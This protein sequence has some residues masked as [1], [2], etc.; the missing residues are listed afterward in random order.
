VDKL[1]NMVE[2]NE[3]LL[4]M[5]QGGSLYR[6][7]ERTATEI[8]AINANKRQKLLMKGALPSTG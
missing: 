3:R 2:N 6:Y 1:E 4:D 8:S 5:I 7:K